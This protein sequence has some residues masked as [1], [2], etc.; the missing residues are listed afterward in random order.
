MKQFVIA[1]LVVFLLGAG[2]VFAYIRLR[3]QYHVQQP[4][5]VADF[6]PVPTDIPMSPS[7][8]ATPSATPTGPTLEIVH[9]SVIVKEG[10]MQQTYTEASPSAAVQPDDTVQTRDNSVAIVDYHQGTV[11]RLGANTTVVVEAQDTSSGSPIEKIQ[12]VAGTIFVRFQKILG[13]REGFDAETP[14]IVAAVR[15]TAYTLS[16]DQKTLRSKLITV[17]HI[18]DVLEKDPKTGKPKEETRQHVGEHQQLIHDL[19]KRIHLKVSK[20]LAEDDEQEWLDF[21]AAADLFD[22]RNPQATESAALKPQHHRFWPLAEDLFKKILKKRAAGGASGAQTTGLTPIT[23]MPGAGFTR[24]L[25]KTSTGEYPLTCIGADKNSMHVVTDSGN[26]NTCANNCTV[27]PLDAYAQRNGAFA[28]INGSY[29]CPASYPQCAGKINSFDT[30]F[31]NSRSHNYL[32]SDNNVYSVLPFLVIDGAGN[33]RF[34][35]HAEQWG[36]DTGIHAGIMGNPLLVQGG[37][38]VVG[39]YS[40]DTRQ[41]TER[42]PRGAFVQKGNLYYLC[43]ASNITVHDTAEL[44][45]TLGADNAMN[46]DGGG[47]AALWVN[48]GYKIGPGRQIPTALMFVH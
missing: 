8:S 14:T 25:V 43:I 15:G 46:I 38:S 11:V 9:G 19:K 39:N 41:M 31:F 42:G 2:A 45:H 24:S 20:F 10:T 18:V 6:S 37:G 23:S 17:E 27:M 21:N 35:S 28:A 26:D 3:P 44:Y 34:I 40:E 48:G 30:L 13:V 29:F 33:A 7:P 47:S 22:Q 16:T 1:S 4:E 12:E 5:P 36:R 32:N